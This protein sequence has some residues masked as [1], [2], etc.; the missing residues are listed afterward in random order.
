MKLRLV[1]M[2]QLHTKWL[3]QFSRRAYAA[4]PTVSRCV[5]AETKCVMHPL[6]G[7][8]MSMGIPHRVIA[9]HTHPHHI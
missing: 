4:T 9:S 2:V 5:R 6:L 1:R 8:E 3:F 7:I